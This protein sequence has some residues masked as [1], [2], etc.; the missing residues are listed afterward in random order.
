VTQKIN[1]QYTIQIDEL[2]GEI[3][4]LINK[5][6][7]NFEEMASLGAEINED[8]VLS[9]RTL[10]K[11][12]S[13]RQRMLMIDTRFQ[14]SYNLIEGYLSYMAQSKETHTET[15]PPESTISD[16]DAADMS[17]LKQR[18]QAFKDNFDELSDASSEIAD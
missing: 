11:I 1:I 5:N 16:S 9:H 13:I 15:T 17:V 18:L 12:D 3:E 10:N 6:L 7:I 8:A 4:R 2:E 14:D